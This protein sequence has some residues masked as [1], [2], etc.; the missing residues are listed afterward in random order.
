MVLRLVLY[1]AL[2]VDALIRGHYIIAALC[3]VTPF[4]GPRGMT[5]A[6]LAAV[7][8]LSDG[9]QVEALLCVGYV[10]FCL[11]GNWYF[12]RRARKELEKLG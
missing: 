7:L 1:A 4:L 3:F 10:V 11:V 2:A 12:D 6:I 9:L 8:F 5:V